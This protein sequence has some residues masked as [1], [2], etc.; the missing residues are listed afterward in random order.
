MRPEGSE[1]QVWK[2]YT[3]DWRCPNLAKT[4]RDI[5][6]SIEDTSVR[7]RESARILPF[8]SSKP[9]RKAGGVFAELPFTSCSSSNCTPI[10]PTIRPI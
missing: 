2:E 4:Q 8:W 1:K 3:P 9:R 7:G 10:R 5:V 6:S